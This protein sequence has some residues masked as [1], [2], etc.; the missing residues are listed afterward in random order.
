MF[1]MVWCGNVGIVFGQ[2]SQVFLPNVPGFW[3]SNEN[4]E[5]I[6]TS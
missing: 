5:C 4:S 1:L 6:L 2:G 3:Q